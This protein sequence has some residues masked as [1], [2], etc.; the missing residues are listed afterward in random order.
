MESP[1]EYAKDIKTIYDEDISLRT[2][3]IESWHSKTIKTFDLSCSVYKCYQD[4][5]E[6]LQMLA[7][8]T[9]V[10]INTAPE[11]KPGEHWLGIFKDIGSKLHF[12][13]SYGR[14]PTAFKGKILQNLHFASIN[15][16]C[17]QH[18]DTFVCGHYIC[19]HMRALDNRSNLSSLFTATSGKDDPIAHENDIKAYKVYKH[20]GTYVFE[21]FPQVLTSLDQCPQHG[22]VLHVVLVKMLSQEM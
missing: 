1:D 22:A 21:F 17:F 11:S 2:G 9:Y 13:D 15:K 12:F 16:K 4:I 20:L 5:N 6:T 3:D 8:N 19:L 18:A 10:V 7:P 14:H